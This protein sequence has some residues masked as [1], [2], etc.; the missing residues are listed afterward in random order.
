[1]NNK[2][3]IDSDIIVDAVEEGTISNTETAYGQFIP[4]III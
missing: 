1:M 3:S 4:A 2:Y